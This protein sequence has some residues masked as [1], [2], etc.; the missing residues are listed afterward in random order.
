MVDKLLAGQPFR[1]QR[2]P[3]KRA[4]WIALDPGNPAISEINIYAT[5]G[6]AHT[7]IGPDYFLLILR[8]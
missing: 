5:P 3:V 4:F 6:M 1:A 7:T 8:S 2:P